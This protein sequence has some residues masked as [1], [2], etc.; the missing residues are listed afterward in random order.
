MRLHLWPDGAC[1]L[2]GDCELEGGCELDAAAAEEPA[3]A[4]A[5]LFFLLF[6]PG[7]FVGG[8]PYAPPKPYAA[9]S[10]P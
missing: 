2:G 3:F 9:V 1:E 6:T 4:L 8:G 5:P 7:G 10:A